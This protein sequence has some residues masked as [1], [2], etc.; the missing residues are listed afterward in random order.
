MS[1]W[2]EMMIMADMK[3]PPLSGPSRSGAFENTSAQ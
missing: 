2:G 1:T 3:R